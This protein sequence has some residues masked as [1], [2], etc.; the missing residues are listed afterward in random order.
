VAGAVHLVVADGVT[1]LAVERPVGVLLANTRMLK[2]PRRAGLLVAVL[3]CARGMATGG[4]VAL[5]ALLRDV[6]MSE[7]PRGSA[8]S[9]TLRAWLLAHLRVFVAARHVTRRAGRGSHV[10]T[11]RA[12]HLLMPGEV[13]PAGTDACELADEALW[14]HVGRE[15]ARVLERLVG[16]AVPGVV[17]ALCALALLGMRC[18]RELA[19]RVGQV[20]V[21]GDASVVRHVGRD[22]ARELVVAGEVR[23]DLAECD[24]LVGEA[25]GKTAVDV[26]LDARHVAVRTLAP[27]RVVGLHLVAAR[28][29][30]RLVG[31]ERR[32]DEDRRKCDDPHD[33]EQGDPG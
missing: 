16:H 23:V 13:R 17:V 9:V 12:A 4:P 25:G 21:A 19:D 30:L 24:E 15:D 1:L 31:C 14:H 8:R 10:V 2:R 22:R 29:E 32:T 7:R 3:A 26:A 11:A 33:D 18:V 6:R 28:A 5:R 27:R 20:L